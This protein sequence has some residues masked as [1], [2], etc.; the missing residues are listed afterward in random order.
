MTAAGVLTQR[1][2]TNISR[3]ASTTSADHRALSQR[4]QDH[5]PEA[6]RLYSV[7]TLTFVFE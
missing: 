2:R 6:R 1:G 5:G 4:D 7:S 3:H